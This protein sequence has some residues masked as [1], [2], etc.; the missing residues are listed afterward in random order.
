M[1]SDKRVP[2]PLERARVERRRAALDHR[3]VLRGPAEYV[4]N[5]VIDTVLAKDKEFLTAMR[6][7]PWPTST[8]SAPGAPPGAVRAVACADRH[9]AGR[10]GPEGVGEVAAGGRRPVSHQSYG[11]RCSG[12]S[13]TAAWPSIIIA[14]RTRSA[15]SRL[16]GG[17]GSSRATVN[18]APLMLLDSIIRRSIISS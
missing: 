1:I 17:T 15:S 13:T 10:S 6:R 4:L 18:P 2:D 7:T 9:G 16:V 14:S 8:P 3:H 11:Q 5:Q 12:S